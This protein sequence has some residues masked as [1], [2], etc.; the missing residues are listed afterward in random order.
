VSWGDSG[1]A[2]TFPLA[3]QTRVRESKRGRMGRN[4]IRL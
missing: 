1:S 3:P 2:E 4:S